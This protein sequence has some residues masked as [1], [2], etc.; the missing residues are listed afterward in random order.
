M[1]CLT[2]KATA[3]RFL[4]IDAVRYSSSSSSELVLLDGKQ[5]SG[6]RHRALEFQRLLLTYKSWKGRW[7]SVPAVLEDMGCG[8]PMVLSKNQDSFFSC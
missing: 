5:S 4:K 1:E 2:P 7:S 8:L 3:N 6:Y